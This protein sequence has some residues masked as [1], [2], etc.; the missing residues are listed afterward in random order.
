MT[1]LGS[2]VHF[3]WRSGQLAGPGHW[4]PGLESAEPMNS[5]AVGRAGV[6]AACRG[7]VGKGSR[8]V[9]W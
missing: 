7:S 3:L 9:E 1:D 6:G 2:V 8:N 5:G 4:I